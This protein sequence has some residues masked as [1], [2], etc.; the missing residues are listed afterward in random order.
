[1]LLYALSAPE[2]RPRSTSIDDLRLAPAPLVPEVRLLMAEDAIVLWA[3]L[4]AEAGHV[5]PP[6]YWASAWT[7]GQGL[8]RYILDHPDT[9]AGRHVLDVASGSGLVAI[10]AA[11][12]GAARVT[13]NDIDPYSIAAINANAHANDVD[14]T[15]SS[16]DLLDGD[17]DGADVVLAG[18]AL[19]HP[20]VAARMLPFLARVVATGVPVLVGDPDRGHLPHDWLERVASYE[21]PEGS[22]PEDEQLQLTSVLAASTPVS[23]AAWPPVCPPDDWSHR[24][25]RS[26]SP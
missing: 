13:A 23:P 3:R 1:M 22:A 18:D 20:S 19:Y 9:V 11:I 16:S 24:W 5:L 17:G 12:A 15:L 26:G 7:G 14:L 2:H 25:C 6:P 21:V 10:A 4:E 8:A